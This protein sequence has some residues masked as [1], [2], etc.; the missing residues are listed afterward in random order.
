[1]RKLPR[2]SVAYYHEAIEAAKGLLGEQ[3]RDPEGEQNYEYTRAIL[4]LIAD[5]FG[6]RHGEED[7]DAAKQRIAKDI[8]VRI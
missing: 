8:G 3:I 4:E 5:T 6:Y 2:M 7:M 1:M